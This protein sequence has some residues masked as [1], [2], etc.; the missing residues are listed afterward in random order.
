MCVYVCVCACVCVC[1]RLHVKLMR[2]LAADQVAEADVEAWK[3]RRVHFGSSIMPVATGMG[4]EQVAR[5]FTQDFLCVL[6]YNLRTGA[7]FRKWPACSP[8]PSLFPSLF[9]LLSSPPS[10]FP[11]LSGQWGW[12]E[13][14]ARIFTQ[15]FLCVRSVYSADMCDTG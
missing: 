5:L 8:S 10:C 15:D 9:F 12:A 4:Q 2:W 13:Q 1:V 11:P 3:K 6:K 14:V 7:C